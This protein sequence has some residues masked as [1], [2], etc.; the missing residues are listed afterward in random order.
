MTRR[1]RHL[2]AVGA[3]L[4]L[5]AGAPGH[6]AAAP[7]PAT[8]ALIVG[9]ADQKPGM[10]TDPQFVGLGLTHAR[11]V[12]PWDVM[13]V[14]WQRDDLR[15]WLRAAHDAGVSP[16]LTFGHS[17][18][19]GRQRLAPSPAALQ[20]Q[21]RVLRLNFPWVRDYATWNEPNH[22]GEPLCKRPE[23]AARYYDALRRACPTCRVLA[24]EVLDTPN[25]SSWVRR[26]RKAAHDEPRYWGLHN[27]VDANRLRTSGTRALLRATHGEVWFTE[28]GGIVRRAAKARIPFPESVSH[29][30]T[31][32]RWLFDRLVPLSPRIKRVYLYH[33]NPLG[34]RDS[35]DSALV[36]VRGRPRAAF[37]VL[38][39]RLVRSRAAAAPRH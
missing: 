11:I 6:A 32:T 35:W 24:A 15:A 37:R 1:R 20:Q 36:D 38:Q 19:A 3:V 16:L 30:A 21:F 22:C 29:A 12:V 18:R 7:R 39:A 25:L 14:S 34:P 23:L 4:L 10:F 27:Y 2:A 13:T 17:R 9:I 31:A 33:W 5:A 26:F 28:T 8:Q